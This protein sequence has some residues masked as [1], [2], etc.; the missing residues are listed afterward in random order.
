M[1]PPISDNHDMDK[2]PVSHG[3]NHQV[4]LNLGDII[5]LVAPTHEKLHEQTFLIE[6]LDDTQLVLLDVANLTPVQLN[7]DAEGYLTDESVQQIHILSRSEEEGYARQN[8]L[9]PKTWVDIHIG[10]ET[11]VI[12]TGQITNLDEDMIEIT[13][14]PEMD[15]IY[16][17]FEYKGIPRNV[18][19]ERFEIREKPAGLLAT[20][21][22]QTLAASSANENKKEGEGE[23]DKNQKE[24]EEDE[25]K[26]EGEEALELRLDKDANAEDYQEEGDLPDK[27]AFDVL[28]SLYLAAD[29]LVFGED[30]DEITQV[31]ELPENQRRYG[32][33]VQANDIMDEMLSTVPNSRRTKEIMGRIHQLIERYKQLRAAFSTF[34]QNNN[35]TGFFQRGPLYKPLVER[36][37]N[38][39]VKLP[40]LVPTVAQRKFIYRN[41]GTANPLG[42]DMDDAEAAATP[43]VV[44]S[45]LNRENDTQR[46]LFKS[47]QKNTLPNGVNKYE[48]LFSK[49]NEINEC[50][51]PETA[52]EHLTRA[53]SVMENMD[54]VVKNFE[55]FYSTVN[56]AT[57]KKNGNDAIERRRFVIQR[58]QL[59]ATKKN[60][61]LLRSGKTVHV[62]ENMVPNDKMTVDS[63]IMLP[64]PAVRFSHVYLP[65][66]RL[67][68]KTNLHHHYMPLF[69][70]LRSK[71]DI[72]SYIIDNLEKAVPY[73]EDESAPSTGDENRPQ[74]LATLKEFVLENDDATATVPDKF[75]KFL[76]SVVPKT[77]VIF[78][79]IR[80]Y[81]K[82]KL[83]LVDIVKELE[84][85][86]IYPQDI[87]YKQYDEIRFFIKQQIAGIR[88]K[89]A[90]HA[91]E[92]KRMRKMTFRVQPHMNRIERILLDNRDLLNMFHDGYHVSRPSES[93]PPS[94]TTNGGQPGELLAKLNSMDG[95]VLF[96]DLITTMMIKTLST[97][98]NILEAFEPAK[99]DDLTETEKIKANDC[100]RRYLA[101]RY[102]NMAEM[103][104]DNGKE[105]VFYD[106]DLDTSAPSY[107]YFTKTYEK[108]RKGMPPAEFFEFLKMNLIH[109]HSVAEAEAET[110]TR[111][112]VEGKK[113]VEDGAYAAVNIRGTTGFTL[114]PDQPPQYE[115]PDRSESDSPPFT[116]MSTGGGGDQTKYFRRVKDQWVHD[117]SIQEEAFLDTA[118]LFCNISSDCFKDQAAGTCESDTVARRRMMALNKLRMKSEFTQRITGSIEEMT[119]NIKRR[120]EADYKQIMRERRL[121]QVRQE[122]YNDYAYDLGKTTIHEEHMES[123]HVGLRNQMMGQDD[124]QKKQADIVRFVELFCREPMID[125]LT[126]NP[127]WLYCR[128]T[129]LTL[130][131]QS[132]YKL[133]V[134]FCTGGNYA[135][136]LSEICR[137]VGIIS[138]DGDSIVDKYTGYV[139]RKI[140]FVTEDEFTDEGL[141]LITHD[142]LEED[143]ETRL[144]KILAAPGTQTKVIFENEQNQ[145][146]YNICKAIC[147]QMGIPTENIQEFV[148]LTTNEL[149]EKHVQSPEVYE[150]KAQALEKKK[151]VRPI[152]YDI[153]KTRF[154][155]WIVASAILIAIQTAVPPFRVK[156][157]FPGCV[158]SFDGYPL[159]GGVEN[160]SGIQYIA[161]IMFKIKS[162]AEPWNA[163]ERLNLET[164]TNKIRETLEVIVLP[165]RSDIEEMYVKKREYLLLHPDEVVPAQHSLDRWPHFLP[166]VVPFSV[167]AKLRPISKEY[168]REMM[169]LIRDGHRDQRNHLS[170]ITSRAVQYGYAALEAINDIVKSKDTLLKT[171]SKIPFLEN[172]CC[173]DGDQTRPLAYFAKENPAITKYVEIVQYLSNLVADTHSLLGRP[174]MLF[175]PGFTGVK[176]PT[177]TDVTLVD[178][179]YRAF[180]H[181][182]HFDTDVP[183]PESLLLVCAEKP[184]SLP[185]YKRDMS[186]TDKIEFLKMNG[187]QYRPENLEQLMT[188]VR[189]RNRIHLDPPQ[190]FTQVDVVRD[191]IQVDSP[192][193][194]GAFRQRLLAV[195]DKFQPMKMVE[196]ARP[197]LDALK[198]Y[199]AKA[200]ERMYYT[201]VDFMDK[202]G[203][204]DD[205]KFHAFQDW[206]MSP[207]AV[208]PSAS[209]SNKDFLYKT[210]QNVKNM[211][212]DMSRLFPEMILQQKIYD[213]IPAHWELAG[214]HV[215]E[216]DTFVQKYWDPIRPFF[217]DAVIS[218]MLHDVTLRLTDLYQLTHALPVYSPI[219]KGDREFH[220]LFDAEATY[221]M[222]IYLLYS[223]LYE[224]IVAAENPDMLRT[225]AVATKNARKGDIREQKDAS[226]QGEGAFNALNEDIDEA[227]QELEEINLN[228]LQPNEFKTR[229]ANLLT[230]FVN[231]ERENTD[232]FF[233]YEEIAKKIG[234]SKK[235]EKKRITDYLGALNDDERK[236][237]NEFKK[238]KM[239]RWNA[240]LQRG[241]V[242]YDKSTFERE[243]AENEADI[244]AGNMATDVD[245]DALE[246]EEQRQIADE[247]DGEGGAIGDYGEEYGDGVYYAEDRDPDDFDYAS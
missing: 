140:D 80:K 193:I 192:V 120:L 50:F 230:A 184:T 14:F 41:D 81:I 167:V 136:K 23:E 143:L 70:L 174:P 216:L 198:N 99:L 235:Q 183:I 215:R 25:N 44:F 189:N 160:L 74:F 158:R 73:Q 17:D 152:P 229:I 39:D 112:I 43:D 222:F 205:A 206:L 196:E 122:K 78:R 38:L 83:S 36:V 96:Y 227:Q 116:P 46:E 19:F 5:Q 220:A 153:Y 217:G 111:A 100:V 103:R 190:N 128:D 165:N 114:R 155:F 37:R 30:L 75:G 194:E 219:M 202:Y 231:I 208:R 225:D 92:Y 236:I 93:E 214:V 110:L 117:T 181:Y 199:L 84:P 102:K 129:N 210:T 159:S 180:F 1:D 247:Y 88:E 82:D 64:E 105:D 89:Y 139:L 3:G 62:R 223:T 186:M 150:R 130:F 228:I 124:F 212:Y 16:I 91:D 242:H 195:M 108:E 137:A 118:T 4:K 157:T 179:I 24:G 164:Y 149:M 188:I 134:V 87:T 61:V 58:Y 204:L 226:K 22:A 177:I 135:T 13:T 94:T 148:A 47:Y 163:I 151:G 238:Y 109:K 104:Q 53:E 182:C 40:W 121:R 20:K 132:L 101:K 85:F 232:V 42:G 51:I 142:I 133:A 119:Q 138:D 127:A 213:R 131:P 45:Q 7:L 52:S 211:V 86:L 60:K 166:P 97:P 161:C 170:M 29:D 28:N 187:K 156:K 209:L 154:M 123:P 49:L 115:S 162:T 6:Y 8:G 26:K 76:N 171:S 221:L 243:R 191:L 173:H 203:N 175:H 126:E 239:G 98:E 241:L 125:T 224:Y 106:K 18:P 107:E 12:L 79:L 11:P 246:A 35:V 197:E 168:E 67:F 21:F 169:D 66:T 201:M 69:R 146:I 145:Q 54:V 71:T 176:Y 31:V 207:G 234:L 55:D 200:N 147:Q 72:G 33:E 65:T 27:N 245:A 113:R 32:V 34:D 185:G 63:V 59:G 144:G 240:G 9:L 10:G 48:Y 244:F 2:E 56:M 95:G 57:T 218:S 172:A 141:R 178:N 68:N 233:T 90:K 237:E 77:R 15:V